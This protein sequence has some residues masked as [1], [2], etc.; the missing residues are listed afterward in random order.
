MRMMNLIKPIAASRW[1]DNLFN[2]IHVLLFRSNDITVL[3]SSFLYK[4]FVVMDKIFNFETYVDFNSIE[5]CIDIR[6]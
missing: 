6:V 3:L 1:L 2:F 4:N 5:L